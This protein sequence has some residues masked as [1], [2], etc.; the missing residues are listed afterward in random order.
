MLLIELVEQ[1]LFQNTIRGHR[2]I[3]PS[4]VCLKFCFL[5]KFSAGIS[6]NCVYFS[7]IFQNNLGIYKQMHI[8]FFIA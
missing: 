5:V 8:F 2:V 7:I 1:F 4:N 3:T 6:A